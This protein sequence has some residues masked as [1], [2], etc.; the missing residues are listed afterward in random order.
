MNS[1]LTLT[2]TLRRAHNIAERV[3]ERMAQ[4]RNELP[5]LAGAVTVR[6][7]YGEA[8]VAQLQAS[9]AAALAALAEHE[10]LAALQADIRA[11][12][13]AANVSS[14]VSAL[15]AKIEAKRKQLALLKTFLACKPHADTLSVRALREWVAPEGGS[16][17][18]TPTAS[19]SALEAEHFERAERER[20]ALERELYALGDELAECNARKVSLEIAVEAAQALGLAATNEAAG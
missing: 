6:G 14:G 13:A 20:S 15:L 19:V 7:F 4:L 17:L 16:A 3:A 8:Q 12:V 2:V 5:E 9:A 18:R 10:R 1:P 11:R